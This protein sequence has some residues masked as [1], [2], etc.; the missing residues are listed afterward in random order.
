MLLSFYIWHYPSILWMGVALVTKRVVNACPRSAI[1]VVHF[2][3][4]AVAVLK[5]KLGT[6][7]SISIYKGE[8]AY[9]KRSEV[10]KDKARLQL[11]SKNFSLKQVLFVRY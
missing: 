7:R 5:A 2:I 3:V 11:H 8:W 9:R 4:G 10:F 6:R 1:L